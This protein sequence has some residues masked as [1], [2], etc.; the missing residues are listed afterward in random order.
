MQPHTLTIGIS[1]DLN[2][3]DSDGLVR[4]FVHNLG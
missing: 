3:K 1:M 4:E 2:G